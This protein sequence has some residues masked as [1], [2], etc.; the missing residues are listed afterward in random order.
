MQC[1]PGHGT[2]RRPGRVEADYSEKVPLWDSPYTSL[3]EAAA[4]H[5]V[6]D[7]DSHSGSISS[8]SK[9][10]YG[11]ATTT[12]TM[13]TTT[14][15]PKATA[16]E[17][18][19][20]KRDNAQSDEATALAV[21]RLL[22]CAPRQDETLQRRITAVLGGRG[23]ARKVVEETVDRVIE[24]VEQGRDSLGP[25]MLDAMDRATAMADQCFDFPRQHPESVDG[26]VA[27]VAVG[28]VVL[29]LGPWVL[30]PLGF[31]EAR[32]TVASGRGGERGWT[33]ANG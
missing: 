22:R 29:M 15:V 1:F 30:D 28:I 13:I 20:G 3:D 33:P 9:L 27:S 32:E 6:R 10:N 12:L 8:T 4:M 16:E 7:K 2:S 21:S 23:W 17:R 24:A 31:A 14:E 11:T 18:E 5:A 19:P 25:A 26:F